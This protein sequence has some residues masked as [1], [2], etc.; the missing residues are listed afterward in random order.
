MFFSYSICHYIDTGKCLK[1]ELLSLVGSASESKQLKEVLDENNAKENFHYPYEEIP[2][3]SG[4]VS[5]VEADKNHESNEGNCFEDGVALVSADIV[6][7]C[8]YGILGGLL[9]LDGLQVKY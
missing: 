7:Y 9:L 3:V 2:P 1:Y 5:L 4:H 8:P 6:K